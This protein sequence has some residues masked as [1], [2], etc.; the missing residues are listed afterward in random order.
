MALL[1]ELNDKE[2]EEQFLEQIEEFKKGVAEER[3]KYEP[4]TA[5]KI[6]SGK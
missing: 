1:T 2:E 5:E 3:K 6:F 4:T